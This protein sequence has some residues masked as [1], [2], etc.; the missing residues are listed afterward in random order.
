MTS[1]DDSPRYSC[2]ANWA[3]L[4]SGQ[5]AWECG[6]PSPLP[7]RE[8]S[9]RSDYEILFRRNRHYN[10]VQG[11]I[12][13]QDNTKQQILA[14]GS[15]SPLVMEKGLNIYKKVADKRCQVAQN[16]WTPERATVWSAVRQSWENIMAD[17]SYIKIAPMLNGMVLWQSLFAMETEVL[18]SSTQDLYGASLEK[19]TNIINSYLVIA[20]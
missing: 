16:W 18:Q 17:K 1:V 10:N 11:W 9:T 3:R 20:E 8:F 14:D 12:H 13:E 4:G 6:T 7:R 19:A 2:T 15:I 5:K